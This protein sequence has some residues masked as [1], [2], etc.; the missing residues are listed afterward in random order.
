MHKTW[1]EYLA[2]LE[3]SE[4]ERTLKELHCARQWCWEAISTQV[5]GS[6]PKNAAQK[7][8]DKFIV[9]QQNVYTISLSK[10]IPSGYDAR[11]E[12]CG[13]SPKNFKPCRVELC[14]GCR[15][16]LFEDVPRM[17][18]MEEWDGEEHEVTGPLKLCPQCQTPARGIGARARSIV[19][20]YFPLEEQ[21]QRIQ[22]NPFL[23]EHLGYLKKKFLER[24]KDGNEAVRKAA[25][26]DDLD[27]GEKVRN[28][29]LQHGIDILDSFLLGMTTDGIALNKHANNSVIPLVM[30]VLNFTPFIRAKYTSSFLFG[31]VPAKGA[32]VSSCGTKRAFHLGVYMRFLKRRLLA[33]RPSCMAN[34]AKRAKLAAVPAISAAA[35]KVS[36]LLLFVSNDLRAIPYINHGR[37]IGAIKNGCHVCKVEALSREALGTKSSCYVDAVRHLSAR[38]GKALLVRIHTQAGVLISTHGELREHYQQV[39]ANAPSIADLAV[40]FPPEQNTHDGIVEK[41]RLYEAKQAQ[42]RAANEPGVPDADEYPIA[43]VP[44]LAGSPALDLVHDNLS[45]PMHMILNNMKDFFHLFQAGLTK[46]LKKSEKVCFCVRWAGYLSALFYDI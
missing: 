45:D 16:Y 1:K 17:E 14:F 37:H 33:L 19:F 4:D 38:N 44:G 46:I 36:A 28:L 6:L 31:I 27:D 12:L 18:V 3:A 23:V 22:N 20:C 5:A 13:L 32:E 39:F 42:M 30:R 24:Y 25:Y 7:M 40:L 9:C 21:L 2:S 15:D 34:P 11:L 26:M 35:P 41:G 43:G 8:I 10:L 29:V